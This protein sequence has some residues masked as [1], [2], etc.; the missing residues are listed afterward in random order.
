[1]AASA[2]QV[3]FLGAR[4]KAFAVLSGR[5]YFSIPVRYSERLCE[6]DP[7]SETTA[8]EICLT[9]FESI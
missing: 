3:P 2:R 6:K 7:A 1:M 8:F 9:F 5:I 4:E